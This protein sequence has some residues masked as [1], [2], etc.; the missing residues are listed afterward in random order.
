MADS[1]DWKAGGDEPPAPGSDG[2]GRP[3]PLPPHMDPRRRGGL[4][5]RPPRSVP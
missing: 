3:T 1:R 4:P 2:S 5:P